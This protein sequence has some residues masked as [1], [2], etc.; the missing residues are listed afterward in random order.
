MRI[1]VDGQRDAEGFGPAG[2]IRYREGRSSS[3]PND[4]Y[5]VIGAEKHD[6]DRTTYPSYSGWIDEVRIS[7]IVRYEGSFTPPIAPFIHDENTV[8]LYPFDEGPEGPCTG[9]V[10]DA[11]GAN[12]GMCRYGS[13]D[14]PAGPVYST[15]TPFGAPRPPV[16]LTGPEVFPLTTTATVSWTTD[17]EAIG[18]VRWGTACGPWTQSRQTSTST[19]SPV[20]A[21]DGLRPNTAYCLQVPSFNGAGSTPWTP[22]EGLAFTTRGAEFNVY[23]PLITR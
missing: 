18:E 22:T 23:L 5:L 12:P 14:R 19:R 13:V 2:D 20:L 4:P 9:Q 3:Y 10:I 1:F 8:A 11:T 16:I 17:V 15:D 6:F 21:L 7:R